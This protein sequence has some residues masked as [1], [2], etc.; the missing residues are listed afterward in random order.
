MEGFEGKEQPEA[1]FDVGLLSRCVAVKAHDRGRP[2]AGPVG[3]IILTILLRRQ[4]HTLPHET[5]LTDRF[6]KSNVDDEI[7]P[8]RRSGRAKIGG[9]YRKWVGKCVSPERKKVRKTSVGR[10]LHGRVTVMQLRLR[11]QKRSLLAS[12][13]LLAW[14]ASSNSPDYGPR[15]PADQHDRRGD[16][17]RHCES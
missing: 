17:P 9:I 13:H 5:L 8:R 12:L 4:Q 11:H 1:I 16:D 14:L 6:G 2:P 7:D 15:A 3:S 10:N